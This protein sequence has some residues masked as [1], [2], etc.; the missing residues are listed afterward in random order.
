MISVS[1]LD[2]NEEAAKALAE[3]I[4]ADVPVET[5][6]KLQSLNTSIPVE[7]TGIWIDPIGRNFEY[8]EFE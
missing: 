6:T 2:G 7:S 3:V 8:L 1:I 4:H 5:D